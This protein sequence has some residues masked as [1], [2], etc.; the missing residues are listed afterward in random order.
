MA[1]V[2][3]PP[4]LRRRRAL[5]RSAAAILM[6]LGASFAAVSPARSPGAAPRADEAPIT[7]IPLPPAADPLKLALGRRLFEDRDLSRDGS[8]AC[9]TC[10]DTITNGAD[11]NRFDR[12][13]DGSPLSFNTS[14]VFNAALSFRLGWEGKIRTLEEQARD[15]F[16]NAQIMGLSLPQVE[17]RLRA[18]SDMVRRFREVYGRPPE[19]AD[20]LDA[21]AT[22]ER[23]LLTP[24]SRFDR[25]L[26]GD[27]SALSAQELGGYALF[28]SLGCISCHQGVNVGGNLFEPHGI[29]HPLASP[30]PKILR[31]PS[32][33]NVATTPP[34]FHDGSAPTLTDAVRK[35]ALAQLDRTLSTA[36]IADIVAFLKTLTGTY[37]GQPVRAAVP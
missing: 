34:Y 33:R 12:G 29:F 10:H 15:S 6:L 30:N 28:R 24:G 17:K 21:I 4:I 5:A 37:H 23:S 31:V 35:M 19:A 1:G 7:P 36:Q 22:Y 8:R 9:A 11:G 32:L 14:T 16:E 2:R 26:R 18:D 25:W 3:Q 20:A 27:A 13:L